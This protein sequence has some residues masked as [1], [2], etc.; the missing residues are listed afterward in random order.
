MFNLH[1]SFIREDREGGKELIKRNKEK[2]T[3][4]TGEMR[5]TKETRENPEGELCLR[6]PVLTRAPAP[7]KKEKLFPL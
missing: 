1:S 6:F 2:K 3:V 5:P 7:A 4:D